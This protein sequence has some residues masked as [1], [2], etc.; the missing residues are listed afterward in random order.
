VRPTLTLFT[1]EVVRLRVI[2]VT[3][4][5]TIP[6][7]V[8][9]HELHVLALDGITLKERRA[10]SAPLVLPPGSRADVLIVGAGAGTYNIRKG[11]DNSG[12]GA[13]PELILGV[14]EVL[15]TR[16]DMSL[17]TTLP[18]PASLPDISASEINAP[19]RVIEFQEAPT[20]GPF[21]DT[22]AMMING[23][24]F[25]PDVINH[26]VAL[27]NVEEWTLRN[28]TGVNHPFHIH[29]NPFQV[30]AI[31]GV[32]LSTPEWRDTV[33]VPK[34]TAQNPGTVTIRTRFR[35]F[36]GVFPLHCH[37]LVHQDM[38]MMQTVWVRA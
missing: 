16:V 18:A 33:Q 28:V 36:A 20:G 21:P 7:A 22:P 8:D 17:P 19:G 34:G 31:N 15:P 14:L 11:V 26:V 9:G 2:N 13:D 30:I 1:G 25:D 4:R 32:R 24:L 10:T 29:V 3:A 23:A 6:F 38:G 27:N 12:N 35:D 5:S 37:I